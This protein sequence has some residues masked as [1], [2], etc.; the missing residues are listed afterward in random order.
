MGLP[1]KFTMISQTK[2]YKQTAAR[3]G[4]KKLF[5]T[6]V[7][8]LLGSLLVAA[9][10]CGLSTL[11]LV[12]PATAAPANADFC[13]A[14]PVAQSQSNEP[15]AVVAQIYFQSFDEL[16]ILA[17]LVDIWDVHHADGSGQGYVVALL[18]A[19]LVAELRADGYTVAV[20]ELKTGLLTWQ[21]AVS[22]RQQAGIP[23][24]PCYRTVEETYDALEKLATDHPN[25]ARWVDIGDSWDKQ[26]A[27]DPPGYDLHAIVV[28]NHARPGPKPVFFLVAAVHAR[29]FTTAETATRFAEYLVEGYATDADIAWLLDTTEIHI[30]AQA[31]PDGR[32]EAEKVVLWR[33]N[34]NSDGCPNKNPFFSYYG[35]D[36]NRNSSFKW[37]QCEGFNCSS[38]QLCVDTFRGPSA[39]SEPET[40]ALESYMR[41]IFADQRGAADTDA[42]PATTTGL[43]ISLHSYSELIIFPWGWRSTP[44]PN[45]AE[46]ETLGR[47]FGY[48]T[49]YEVCQS[50]EPGCIYQTDGTTDD[51]AYGELGVA[52]YTF[53]L[54]TEFFEQCTYF[55]AE[56]ID[57]TIAAL[58]YA[59]KTAALPYQLPAGPETLA[60]SVTLSNALPITGTNGLTDTRPITTAGPTLTVTATADDTRYASNGWGIEATQSISATRLLIS[61]I[62][63][64]TATQVYSMSARDGNFDSAVEEVVL[65][66]PLEAQSTERYLLRLQSQDSDGNW[67]TV[68][69]TYALLSAPTALRP[70]TEPEPER[71]IYLPFIER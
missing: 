9:L 60:L 45:H 21:P 71:R 31:N 59:A 30:V 35:V 13:A 54:G 24:Y 41:S 29:E 63:E 47:K 50:G 14:S 16:Q 5:F 12:Q 65:Q 57:D 43:M 40:Q 1:R 66:L 46:L 8:S 32:K 15:G 64:I 27:A 68:T 69:A 33:K 52:A 61:P 34:T 56:I 4:E 18:P 10:F 36:L 23:G 39:A 11:W 42:A 2:L 7:S 67:G 53:E 17:G 51:W 38:S 44:S 19:T 58:H 6:T 22:A 49:G 48:F 70:E 28:T 62:D 3:W 20:D 55:E 26:T 37:N 25:L